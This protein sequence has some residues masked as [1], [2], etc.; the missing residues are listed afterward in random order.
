MTDMELAAFVYEKCRRNKVAKW[1]VIP[2]NKV[3]D[4]NRRIFKMFIQIT[5]QEIEREALTA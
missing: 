1:E 5:R 3:T 4:E 2:W